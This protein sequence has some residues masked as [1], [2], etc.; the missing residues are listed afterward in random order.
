MFSFFF[1]SMYAYIIFRFHCIF[2]VPRCKKPPGFI[3]LQLWEARLVD[4]SKFAPFLE[5]FLR[6]IGD[7]SWAKSPSEFGALYSSEKGN[8]SPMVRYYLA[9]DCWEKQQQTISKGEFLDFFIIDTT[10]LCTCLI[11]SENQDSE[12]LP[13]PSNTGFRNHPGPQGH[14]SCWLWEGA[15]DQWAVTTG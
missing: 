14:D 6:Q 9:V 10:V 15:K 4:G 11:F 3:E 1:G 13:N 7:G 5:N 8:R 2:W 12:Y